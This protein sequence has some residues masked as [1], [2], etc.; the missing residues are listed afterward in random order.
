MMRL[1]RVIPSRTM[2]QMVM[3]PKHPV[4]V[5]MILMTAEKAETVS[6]SRIMET[7][8]TMTPVNMMHWR[9]WLKMVRYWSVNKK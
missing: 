1:I 3:N 2:F 4:R 6:G 5:L 9:L 7:V 8:I